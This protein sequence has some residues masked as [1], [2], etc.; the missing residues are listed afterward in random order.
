MKTKYY[1]EVGSRTV[2]KVCKNGKYIRIYSSVEISSL[3]GSRFETNLYS[4]PF[5]KLGKAYS[6]RITYKQYLMWYV[7]FVPTPLDWKP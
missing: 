6:P 3:A 4:D 5:V 1:W 2:V 7:G